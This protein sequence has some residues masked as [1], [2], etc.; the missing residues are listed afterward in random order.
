[1]PTDS[2]SIAPLGLATAGVI[3]RLMDANAISAKAPK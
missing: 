3:V 1:M 2:D